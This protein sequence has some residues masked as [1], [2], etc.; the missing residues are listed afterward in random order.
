M[1]AGFATFGIVTGLAVVV[2]RAP[3]RWMGWVLVALGV[4]AAVPPIAFFAFLATFLC[5]LVAGI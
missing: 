5:A 3:A 2:S 1:V 4:A